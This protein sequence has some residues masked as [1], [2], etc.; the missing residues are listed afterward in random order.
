VVAPA[1]LLLAPFLESAI[2]LGMILALSSLGIRP[3]FTELAPARC[4]FV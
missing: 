4:F 3:N 2:R 1:P